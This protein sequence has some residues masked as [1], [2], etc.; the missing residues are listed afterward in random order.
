LKVA[1]EAEGIDCRQMC[2]EDLKDREAKFV[3]ETVVVMVCSTTGEGDPPDNA[4]K[5]YRRVK[6]KKLEAN[7]LSHIHYTVLG[8]GDTNYSDFCLVPKTFHKQMTK[9]GATCFYEPGYADD[10]IG[11]ELVIE[12]WREGLWD[13]M[14]TV[15]A[16]NSTGGEG[17]GGD[18]PVAAAVA[19]AVASTTKSATTTTT[20]AA[21]AAAEPVAA[22]AT[23]TSAVAAG[24]D[25]SHLKLPKLHPGFLDC[26]MLA[27][28]PVEKYAAAK[29]VEHS[30]LT[31]P[32]AVK[33]AIAV[34]LRTA[35]PT[36]YAPGDTFAL[37]CPNNTGEVASLL[38][39]LDLGAV[40]DRPFAFQITAG[41]K[42]AGAAIP[43]HL[44]Q[45]STY[46]QCLQLFCD[47]R[48]VLTKGN[49]RLLAEYAVDPTE[50]A[51]MLLLCSRQGG[52]Q[53]KAKLAVRNGL[54]IIGL[55]AAYPSC[56]PP[57]P[58]VLEVLPALHPRRYSCASSAMVDPC[59]VRFV[60]NV[61]ED[62]LTSSWLDALGCAVK[63][64]ESIAVVPTI[65]GMPVRCAAN[66]HLL[67]PGAGAGAGAASGLVP[68]RLEAN[69]AKFS[70]P[71][72]T[73]AP[74]IMIG[75]GTGVAPFLGFLEHRRAQR[76]AAPEAAYGPVYLFCGCRNEE[77]DFL[78]REELEA[79]V[80]DGTLTSL[81]VGFSRDAGS[82]CKYVTCSMK[83]TSAELAKLMLS[84]GGVMYL[85]GNSNTI[86]SGI[87]VAISDLLKEHGGLKPAEVT[88]MKISWK[89]SGRLRIEHYA[90][91]VELCDE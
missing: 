56:Q 52:E 24:P 26:M 89:E 46:R 16:A 68:L 12:P 9:L 19:T 53:Y 57:M 73:S 69:A 1:A 48:A 2:M 81:K 25:T 22:P 47:L 80:A 87:D 85:C 62:G 51:A 34:T 78:L 64:D 60:L 43:K 15:F 32:D 28:A 36:G 10:G 54:S 72:D 11:L 74:L 23:E 88:D 63:P 38:E 45:A 29:M 35:E 50:Q 55:L 8:L 41:T 7:H 33:R 4:S 59:R 65:Y 77:K 18:V 71:E 42:K 86:V 27:P 44:D 3:G 82:A 39:R 20:V 67:Q 70:P 66:L 14:R 79:Y 21:P 17:G 91:P 49:I 37:A 40:A 31:T 76:A 6:S 5:L 13:S 61:V 75:P 83:E 58:R 90:E 30:V 84:D